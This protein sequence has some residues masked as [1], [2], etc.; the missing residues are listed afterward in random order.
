[1]SSGAYSEAKY[2]SRSAS[3]ATTSGWSGRSAEIVIGYGMGV[4]TNDKA[5]LQHRAFVLKQA[6]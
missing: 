2:A 3:S 6:L 4:R 5:R 1:L